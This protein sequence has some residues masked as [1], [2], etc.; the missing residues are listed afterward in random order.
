MASAWIRKRK[1]AG[2]DTRYRVHFR[3]GGRESAERYGGVFKTLRE[4]KER[5]RVI[6]NELAGLRMPDIRALDNVPVAMTVAAAAETW[7]ASRLDVK[8]STKVIYRVAL[9]RLLPYLGSEPIDTLTPAQIAEWVAALH[10]KNYA[11]STIQKSLTVLRQ[12]L[13]HHGIEPNVARDKRVKLPREVREEIQPP[14]RDH[15]EAV[16]SSVAPR[17]RLP[18]VVLE[19]CGQRIGELEQLQWSD[20]DEGKQRWRVTS[21]ASKTSKPRWVQIPDDVWKA[22]RELVPREDRDPSGRVFPNLTQERLRTE[23][24]RAC[25]ATGTPHFS[26]HDL[27]HRRIS[28][29][30]REGLPWAE[31]GARVGQR[32]LSVTADTYTHVLADGEVRHGRYL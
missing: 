17:Y 21:E 12:V 22:V 5:K 24:Q 11:R 2:G 4:A 7:R 16:L 32:A 27:R 30:H 6:E 14:T 9:K 20:L 13:D 8:E 26:P 18:L 15:V 1:T 31:I 28:L 23:I 25:R 10:A 19:A 29:W 3:T